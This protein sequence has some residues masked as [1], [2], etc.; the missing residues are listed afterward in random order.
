ERDEAQPH[1]R[2]ASLRKALDL[3]PAEVR[4][5]PEAGPLSISRPARPRA[6]RLRLIGEAL[7]P[8]STTDGWRDLP[9]F[10]PGALIGLSR[11]ECTSAHEEALTIALLLRR[12]LETP[13]ATAALVTPDRELARRVAAELRRWGIEIDD[14]AGMPLNLTPPGVFLRLV[15]DVAASGLAPV[16]LLSALK[17][18]LA[19]GGMQPANFRALARRLE[20]VIRGPR[21]APGFAGLRAA[22]DGS[23]P[24]LQRFADRLE[25]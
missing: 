1:A 12:K 6:Q 5:W 21:P 22:L 17:H 24:R 9:R 10:S 3:K 4:E 13:G 23:E 11:Y 20:E 16:P 7:R 19:A 14:S 15:L 18:P 25:A 8:A 2:L